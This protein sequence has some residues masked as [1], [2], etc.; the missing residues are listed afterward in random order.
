[1][2]PVQGNSVIS[3]GYQQKPNWKRRRRMA[4]QMGYGG[5]RTWRTD[6]NFAQGSAD[7]LKYITEGDWNELEPRTSAYND[8]RTRALERLRD[9]TRAAGAC[10]A[11]DVRVRRGPF[12]HARRTVEFTALGT[13]VAS[14]RF[15]AQDGDPIPLAGVSGTDFWKLVEVGVWPLGLVGGTSVVYILSAQRTRSARF[16]GSR[17]RYRNQEYAD[18]TQGLLHARLGAA[19][20]LKKAALK[21]GASGVIGVTVNMELQEERDRDLT[22]TVELLGTAVAPLETSAPRPVAYALGLTQA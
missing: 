11:V 16:R 19:D 15:E 2:G 8:V 6:G 4:L 20:R 21:L 7:A 1:L 13:A 9:A 18:Y 17:R 12:G 22:V 3:L 5:P 14:E 10:A